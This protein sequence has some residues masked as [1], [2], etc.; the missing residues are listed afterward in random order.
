ML[1]MPAPKSTPGS[2]P[3]AQPQPVAQSQPVAQPQPVGAGPPSVAGPK[4]A[5]QTLLGLNAKDL[6]GAAPAAVQAQGPGN[7]D[8]KRTLIG[9][10]AAPTSSAPP[11]ARDG[12][13]QAPAAAPVG[14]TT[15]TG[16]SPGERL[17]QPKLSSTAILHPGGD[18][19]T[20]GSTLLGMPAPSTPPEAPANQPSAQAAGA[21]SLQAPTPSLGQ[22]TLLGVAV[23]G[24][25]PLNPGVEP[26][27][28]QS[29]GTAAE[30]ATP[31]HARSSA[32]PVISSAPPPPDDGDDEWKPHARRQRLNAMMLLGA[33]GLLL[34]VL[35]GFMALWDP[36]PPLQV[37]LAADPTGS[38]RLEFTCMD[39]PS[40]SHVSFGDNQAN[41][42]GQTAVL[43]MAEP[44]PIGNNDIEVSLERGGMG[45]DE[46]I[47]L[48]VPVRSRVQADV[49]P[50][51]QGATALDI[52]VQAA[53]EAQVTL[54]GN[55]VFLAK[56]SARVPLE[57]GDAIV[58]NSV[59]SE[60]FEKTVTYSISEPDQP[61]HDGSLQVRLPIVPL[62]VDA[63]RRMLITESERF[64]LAGQTAPG[65]R[66]TV[67]GS[68][69]PTAADGSFAQLM[70]ID[71]VGETTITV[72]ADVDGHAPRLVRIAMKRVP[73]LEDE[74]KTFAESID[75][76]SLLAAATAG[77]ERRVALD[78]QVDEA[79]DK[80]HSSVLLA[81]VDKGC[82]NAP[83]LVQVLCG[84]PFRGKKG[85]TLHVF[86]L[87]SGRIDGPAG[88]PIPVVDAAFS[89]D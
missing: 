33:A 29:K 37:R 83:C 38:E 60:L 86:G 72:R 73:K 22:R 20:A 63:P 49:T 54:D 74:A 23:P 62:A 26:L 44:L 53:D 36:A 4:S 70:S 11:P 58:G 1:G 81:H 41:F 30:D 18:Q 87:V 19:A 68:A 88:K 84:Q 24:V 59:Q 46:L 12:A 17:A 45:R 66:L 6:Y 10:I 35:V 21:A 61:A 51:R 48:S 77:N 67:A 14:R 32:P 69:I 78:A 55:R 52:V 7:F 25:A 71:S 34:V 15:Q 47:S 27:A 50:L 39:C 8:P 9:G 80:A 56:G 65:A 43:A 28:S 64:M 76:A 13:S 16:H 82:E 3:A 31:A 2:T 42:E 75:Y 5:K 85:D 89:V 57:L 79:R 40:G